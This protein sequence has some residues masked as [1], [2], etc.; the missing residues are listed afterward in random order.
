[1][2]NRRAHTHNVQCICY[3]LYVGNAS[4]FALKFE[5]VVCFATAFSGDSYEMDHTTNGIAWRA[6][7]EREQNKIVRKKENWWMNEQTNEQVEKIK[8]TT[9]QETAKQIQT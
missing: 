8:E 3:I 2:I 5:V 6:A 4:F 9:D 7:E 1:M